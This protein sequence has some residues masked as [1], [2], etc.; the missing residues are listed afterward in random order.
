M[1]L[2]WGLIPALVL[3]GTSAQAKEYT[4]PPRAYDAYVLK[5]VHIE[6]YNKPLFLIG[7]LKNW[8]VVPVTRTGV[9]PDTVHIAYF[10]RNQLLPKP[11][12]TCDIAYHN[13]FTDGAS[14]P[15][16]NIR[17]PNKI[18]DSFTCKAT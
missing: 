3:A 13:S 7:Y 8:L 1:N 2:A 12:Q 11:G 5:G 10:D 18:M 16:G 9:A 6:T 14:T 15:Q 17:V 4:L